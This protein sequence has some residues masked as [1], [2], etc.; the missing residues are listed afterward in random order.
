MTAMNVIFGPMFS[1][2]STE[3]IRRMKRYQIAKHDCLLIKYANDDRYDKTDVVT[4]D[5]QSLPALMAME[6]TQMKEKALKVEVIGIDEGQFFPDVSDFCEDMANKGKVVIVA[7]LDGTFQR[8]G[9][10]RILELVPLAE[11]VVKLQAVCVICYCNASYT[12]RIGN[13]KEDLPSSR[14]GDKNVQ[15][16]VGNR[17]NEVKH[18][19]KVRWAFIAKCYTHHKIVELIGGSDK[20]MAVCRDCYFDKFPTRRSPMKRCN[21]NVETTMVKCSSPIKRYLFANENSNN[22]SP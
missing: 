16:Q 2:K 11:S 9:F 7:A 13:E 21:M 5:R 4:H 14:N 3:L 22:C 19:K 12:K 20:Y 18:I 1:G 8:V 17:N 15:E 6:L 10:G